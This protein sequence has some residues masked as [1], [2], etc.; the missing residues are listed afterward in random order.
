MLNKKSKNMK[1]LIVVDVQNDFCPG[2][3]LAVPG[4]DEVI[5]VINK[6]LPKFDIV[7]FTKD[8]HPEKM[9][10]FA[11]FHDG[12]NPLE[13]VVLKNGEKDLLWP[14]HCIAETPGAELHKDLDFN[15]IK[16]D[17]YIFKKGLDAMGGHKYSGFDAEGLSD[18]LKEKN[19]T[20]V[21]VT[22]LATDYCVKETALDSVKNGFTTSLVWDACRGI[23][24]DLTSTIYELYQGTVMV[25]DF[26]TIDET[27]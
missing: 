18:F 20:E 9:E 14:D 5:P 2:G 1:A 12:K 23:S 17:F 24:E 25:T 4:G 19:V 8:W 26:E 22:G 13:E 6:L 3:N 15:L 21:I 10:T 11:S 16:G 7:I 27:L